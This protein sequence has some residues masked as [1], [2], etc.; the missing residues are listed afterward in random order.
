MILRFY[1]VKES[2]DAELS[3]VRAFVPFQLMPQQGPWV[4][5]SIFSFKLIMYPT[6]IS[7]EA[8]ATR[9]Y[10]NELLLSL[11]MTFIFHSSCMGCELHRDFWSYSFF[12]SNLCSCL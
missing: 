5:D 8:G 11:S 2:E 1:L 4:S 9:D 3:D 6:R 7:R 10:I 12:L